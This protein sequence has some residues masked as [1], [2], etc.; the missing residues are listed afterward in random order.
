MESLKCPNCETR[1]TFIT[2]AKA[3]TPWHLKCSNCKANLKIGKYQII[4]AVTAFIFG[5]IIAA[6]G[7]QLE[8]SLPIFILSIILLIIAFEYVGFTILKVLRVNLRLQA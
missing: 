4:F 8:L 3:P 6:I 7:I 5:M 1:M 2:F